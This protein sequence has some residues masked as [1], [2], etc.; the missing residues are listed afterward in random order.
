[1]YVITQV[2]PKHFNSVKYKVWKGF[3]TKNVI[4]LVVTGILNGTFLTKNVIHSQVRSHSLANPFSSRSFF[5]SHAFLLQDFRSL[6]LFLVLLLLSLPLPK[7]LLTLLVHHFSLSFQHASPP[8]NQFSKCSQLSWQT[9]LTKLQLLS[10][11]LG[12]MFILVFTGH[13][14][15]LPTFQAASG[16]PFSQL[17]GTMFVLVLHCHLLSLPMFQAASRIPFSQLLGTMF[18]LVL[19]CHL[20]SL[21]TF[22]AASRI[23]FSQL[24]GT[25]FVLVLPCHLPSLPTFQVFNCNL[26]VFVVFV[27]FCHVLALPPLQACTAKKGLGFIKRTDLAQ[28]SLAVSPCHFPYF[29]GSK[30]KLFPG[31]FEMDWAAKCVHTFR[32]NAFGILAKRRQ[33][34]AHLSKDFQ[35]ANNGRYQGR[36]NETTSMLKHLKAKFE[37][38]QVPSMLC[39]TKCQGRLQTF[40]KSTSAS[41]IL[42]LLFHWSQ[43]HKVIQSSLQIK[44]SCAHHEGVKT[45]PCKVR[46]GAPSVPHDTTSTASRFRVSPSLSGLNLGRS[47]C[48]GHVRLAV[49]VSDL[50]IQ[51]S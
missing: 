18:V 45:N 6:S 46:T 38:C 8:C 24:L 9:G 16:I 17:L 5:C 35:A 11:F 50:W 1:M 21:P 26:P 25:M 31:I 47:L 10:Q 29:S 28:N 32:P 2:L 42:H 14:P 15:S 51:N 22:Q 41:L 19:H 23:P 36:S 7:Y 3:P 33:H 37:V 4:I 43:N 34:T 12:T 48:P 40:H 27:L 49:T 39:G 13:L 20:P 30:L 44:S